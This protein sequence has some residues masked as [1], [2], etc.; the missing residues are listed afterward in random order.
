MTAVNFPYIKFV[1]FEQIDCSNSSRINRYI[2]NQ[3]Y[4]YMNCRAYRN[5]KQIY[6]TF[7]GTLYCH[8]KLQGDTL[9]VMANQELINI[10]RVALDRFDKIQEW[11]SDRGDDHEN[12]F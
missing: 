4:L 10:C 2:K 7:Q 1:K 12:L 5:M 8:L 6:R 11:H 3:F 9:T